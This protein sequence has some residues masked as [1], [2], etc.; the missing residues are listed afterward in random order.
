MAFDKSKDKVLFQKVMETGLGVSVHSYNGGDAKLQI[1]PRTYTKRD[2]S[3]GYG[4]A[5][6]LVATEVVELMKLMPIIE[7][8]VSPADLIE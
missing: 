6:R 8:L 1:G 3:T 4:K 2:G 7:G 5:G